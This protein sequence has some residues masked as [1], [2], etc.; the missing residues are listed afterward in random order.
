MKYSFRN[1]RY[2][3]VSFSFYRY[4]TRFNDYGTSSSWQISTRV[5]AFTKK[6][7]VASTRIP[8]EIVVITS[9]CQR[10]YYNCWYVVQ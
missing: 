3:K 10:E 6:Y 4:D 1:Y 2:D 9:V 5:G 8:L 7:V